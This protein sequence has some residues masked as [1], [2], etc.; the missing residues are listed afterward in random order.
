MQLGGASVGGPGA[1]GAVGRGPRPLPGEAGRWRALRPA[2][3]DFT[4]ETLLLRGNEQKLK[5]APWG[6]NP[7][8]EASLSLGAVTGLLTCRGAS[9]VWGP[10][11][12]N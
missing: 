5:T 4:Y 6:V 10:L 1:P 9:P 12:I 2:P 7:S 3:P 8:R 11:S